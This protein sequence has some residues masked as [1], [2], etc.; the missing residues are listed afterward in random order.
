MV[1]TPDTSLGGVAE[2]WLLG[3]A[4][5]S[6]HRSH[7][8]RRVTGLPWLHMEV[9]R[10]SGSGVRWNSAARDFFDGVPLLSLLLRL[11]RGSCWGSVAGI[12]TA[13]IAT[14]GSS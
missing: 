13:G 9:R 11:L 3:V 7:S 14:R 10:G 1:L 8:P 6:G 12:G 5:P 2:T 4:M